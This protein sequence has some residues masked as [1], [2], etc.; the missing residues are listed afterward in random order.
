MLV[1]DSRT[2][3]ASVGRNKHVYTP[4]Y[5]YPAAKLLAKDEAQRIAANIGEAMGA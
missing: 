2:S 3:S 4:C 5:L 1:R